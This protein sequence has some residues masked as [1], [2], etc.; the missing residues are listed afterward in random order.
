[1]R[2]TIIKV[3]IFAVAF[4]FVESAVVVYL[5]HLLGSTWSATGVSE[6]LFLVPG[7]AFLEPQ[8]AVKI[9]SDTA[10]LNIERVREAATLVMLGTVALLAAKSFK[11]Q[12]AFFFVAFGIWDIF[13]Y[14]FLKLTI[15]WP[16]SLTDLD[17][18][19]LLPTPWVGPVYVPILISSFLVLISMV[20]LVKRK[21]L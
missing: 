15:N 1:M 14:I 3:A 17:T 10:I 18:F 19:F 2:S 21:Q 6:I 8:T 9:I 12:I 4:A 11:E 13:Y 7:I 5:R 20:Y 16:A